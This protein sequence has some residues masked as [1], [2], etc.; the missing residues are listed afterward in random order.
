MKL[1]PPKQRKF[2]KGV[3][4]CRRCGTSVGVIRKYGLYI[5]RR[6]INEIGPKLGFKV[7]D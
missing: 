2:G 4:V 7:Y 1:K 3:H 5:C 6:C